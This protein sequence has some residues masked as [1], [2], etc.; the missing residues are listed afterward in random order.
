MR[1]YMDVCCLNRPFDD[2]SQDRIFFEAEA[3]LAILSRCKN[4]E[5]QLVSS[6]VIDSELSK[7]SD[8]DKLEKV[9]ELYSTANERLLLDTKTEQRAKFFQKCGM[10]PFDSLHLA[11]AET[12]AVDVF[13][14][15]DDKLLRMTTTV[16]LNIRVANPAIWLV[17]ALQ[18]E[19]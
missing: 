12:Y 11:L 8:E 14:T 5:W 16:E 18:N 17:E 7:S 10:Q 3:V 1:I 6:G 9:L 13:L 19:Y 2:A 4:G 15:T